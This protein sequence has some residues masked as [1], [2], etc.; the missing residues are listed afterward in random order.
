M[1]H[2]AIREV[3]EDRYPSKE[4]AIYSDL[5]G[6]E[7]ICSNG[8]NNSISNNNKDVTINNNGNSNN[9]EITIDDNNNGNNKI[10]NNKSLVTSD[11]D[12]KVISNKVTTK[13]K[14]N[15][16]LFITLR[17]SGYSLK[18]IY[19]NKL[20]ELSYFTLKNYNCKYKK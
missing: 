3:L 15:F 1:L 14:S 12:E 19:E 17:E 2:E 16:D 10:I 18:Q 20:L 9:E 6:V 8:N 11:Q 7:L 5:K 4:D 13:K